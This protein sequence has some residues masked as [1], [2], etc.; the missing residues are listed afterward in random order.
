MKNI[1]DFVCLNVEEKYRIL[2]EHGTFLIDRKKG[3]RK[4]FLYH[5]GNMFCEVWILELI[6]HNERIVTDIKI[7]K[8]QDYLEPYLNYIE[9]KNI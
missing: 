7:F 2:E 4:I 5:L 1:K 8:S 6:D 9:L 3:N